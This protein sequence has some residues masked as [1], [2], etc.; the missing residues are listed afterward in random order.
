MFTKLIPAEQKE[1]ILKNKRRYRRID[2][3][4]NHQ[5]IIKAIE[6][7]VR[8][9]A[10]FPTD[11]QLSE[12]TGLSLKAVRTHK[13]DLHFENRKADYQGLTTQ[14]MDALYKK[15]LTGNPLAIKLW[16][17]IVENFVEPKE[18]EDQETKEDKQILGI[19]AAVFRL[20]EEERRKR[21][22]KIQAKLGVIHAEFK[23]AG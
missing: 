20:T 11:A 4:A 1:T 16:M 15:C 3:S 23:T 6:T 14:V 9:H 18:A 21:L 17:Q 22:E 13:H 7:Y 19:T 10:V 5:L 2:Y 8:A 12:I